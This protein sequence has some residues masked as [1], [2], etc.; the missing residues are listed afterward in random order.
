V[1]AEAQPAPDGDEYAGLV[2]RAIAITIDAL[3]INVAALAVTG[4]V[5]M[6]ESLFSIS[7]KHNKLAALIGAIVFAV[8]LITYFAVFWTTTGQTPGSRVMHIRVTR[9]DGGRLR[10]RGALI[11]LGGMAISLPLF[12]GYLPVLTNARRRAAFDVLARTVVRIVPPELDVAGSGAGR[13]SQVSHDFDLA[14]RGG[15][16]H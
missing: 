2:T 5:L 8:W 1:I 11:R 13:R 12:W 14:R 9:T 6:L 15:S 16:P 10:P 4:A 7:H 3:L